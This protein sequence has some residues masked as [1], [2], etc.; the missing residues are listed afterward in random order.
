MAD[1]VSQESSRNT[2]RNLIGWLSLCLLAA[3][4]GW[5]PQ[6]DADFKHTLAVAGLTGLISAV[7]L[8][9]VSR[10]RT[11][12]VK[13]RKLKETECRIESQIKGLEGVMEFHANLRAGSDGGGR[14]RSVRS[15]GDSERRCESRYQ[16]RCPVLVNPLEGDE[17]SSRE[18]SKTINAH[19]RDISAHGVGLEHDCPIPTGTV[20]LKFLLADDD[21]VSIVAMLTW[22]HRET[23][24][25]YSSG[26]RLVEVVNSEDE[27]KPLALCME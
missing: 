10:L 22:Q 15:R 18:G 3:G 16:F 2:V 6:S 19:V 12:K 23:D 25:T 8:D 27:L 9:A 21:A 7:G 1:M 26:G 4:W 24:E 17:L 20:L 13:R 5:G 11:S 14:E